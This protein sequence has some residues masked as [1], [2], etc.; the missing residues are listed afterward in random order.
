MNLDE[1]TS[2]SKLDSL[3]ML[4][5]IDHLP[6]QLLSAWEMGQGLSQPWL[7]A[8]NPGK[9][10]RQVVLGG[11]GGSGVGGDLLATYVASTC[12]LP[13]H[14]WRDY[15]LPAWAHGPETLVIVSSHSGD[16]E[17]TL[18]TFEAARLCDCRL[19]AI[20]TTGE[21]ERRTLAMSQ[22]LWKFEHA[23]QPRSA[24]GFSFGLLL[25]AFSR[26]GLLDETPQTT[27]AVV[28]AAVEQMKKQ[29]AD[30][31]AIV[32]VVKNPAKR[33]AGQ[34][35]GRW[36]N[37]YGGGPLAPV[38]CRWK[39]QVNELAKAGAG[40]EVL[41]EADH[42]ALAGLIY[43]MDIQS[44]TMTLFLRSSFDHPRNQLRS[45]LTRHGF[46]VEGLT[47]DVYDAQGETPLA[48]MWTALHFGDY[49]AYYLAML[50]GADPTP[51]EAL[52]NFKIVMKVA[53][54]ESTGRPQR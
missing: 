1:N 11:M 5:Q 21:L 44:H 41:P 20:C 46:M 51:V 34:L 6:D 19:L 12:R 47:T 18:S 17:E 7:G 37:V 43:P 13:V 29:Q 38:A 25:A 30:L 50:Y 15:G 9:S 24:V 36:V 8:E 23:G 4:G 53:S 52:A 27:S 42:N 49:M 32:P 35:M 40:F 3:N 10:I 14:T 31:A 28:A 26:L 39:T 16:T 48:Q 33:Q 45:E 2:F 54:G 22:P